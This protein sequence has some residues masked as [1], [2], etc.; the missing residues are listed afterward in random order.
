MLGQWLARGLSSEASRSQWGIPWCPGC[1]LQLPAVP[2]SSGLSWGPRE[3]PVQQRIPRMSLCCPQALSAHLGQPQ[4][5]VVPPLP[6]PEGLGDSIPHP[7]R[8]TVTCGGSDQRS[9]RRPL[10]WNCPASLVVATRIYT[11][12]TVH[13]STR[14]LTSE[15]M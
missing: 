3:R 6:C 9:Q 1:P 11:E 10:R 2:L 7:L 4:S 5:C 14:T 15:H 13:R 12:I 8:K